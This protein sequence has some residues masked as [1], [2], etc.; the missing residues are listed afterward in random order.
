MALS[1]WTVAELGAFYTEHRSELLSHANRVLK[2][3]AKAEEITQDS[4]IKFMLAAPELESSEHALSYLHR[5]IENL[6]IDY[7]RMEGRRPNLV[8]LD[9]AQAEVEATWQVSG[10]HS[11]VLSQAE[12][13]AIIRQALALLSPAE[14]AAL[15]MWEMEGRSTSEIAAEL[16]I[17]ESAVRHTVSRARTSLRRVLS[18]LVI[19]HERGLTAL[20]MLSTTYKKAADLAA[21][22]S[23]VALSLLLVVTAFLGFNS[24]TGREGVLPTATTQ[25]P[26]AK[27]AAP[28][29]ATEA[30]SPTPSISMPAKKSSTMV[31]GV[32]IKGAKATWPGLDS[33]GL[34]TA[35]TVTGENGTLGKIRINRNIPEATEQGTILATQAITYQGGPNVSIDQSITV[36]GNGT[37]YEVQYVSFGINGVWAVAEARATSVD[38]ERMSN[39]QYLTTVTISLLSTPTSELSIPVGNRGYDVVGAPKTITTRLLLNAS[40]TQILAQAILI[41]EPAQKAKG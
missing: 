40:K 26:T 30:A 13:A 17:K 37:K 12:D 23:K 25:E 38:F 21:K 41:P 3:S 31:S 6:C 5:T 2:D 11:A 7:F 34:P 32:F 14:R 1:V 18:E 16:G 24:L 35:F 36:D 29:E 19:D 15:V 39:G 20:D 8:V 28:S 10:D 4:L 22:S 27:V 33:E 9:D